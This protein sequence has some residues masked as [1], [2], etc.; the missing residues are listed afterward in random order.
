VMASTAARTFA[1]GVAGAGR[2][3]HAAAPTATSAARTS[4][5]GDTLM[6]P[7]PPRNR[8][9]AIP[10][11]PPMPATS[12]TARQVARKRKAP[13]RKKATP[14]QRGLSPSETGERLPDEVR[15]PAAEGEAE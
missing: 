4:A 11:P 14:A 9:R 12:R 3:N 15:G 7:P 5:M 8:E 1:S 13:R 10:H 2:S 6:Q